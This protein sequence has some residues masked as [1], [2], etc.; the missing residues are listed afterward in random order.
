MGTSLMCDVCWDKKKVI[1]GNCWVAYFDILGFSKRV[2]EL[3]EHLDVFV[4]VYYE[5]ILAEI[6]GRSRRISQALRNEIRYAWFSDTFIFFSKDAG[7]QS[8]ISIELLSREFLNSQIYARHPLRGALSV[9]EFYSEKEKDIFVGPALIDAY[10]YA[11]RQN[12]IG[13]VLTPKACGN[14]NQ[15]GIQDR[16][17]YIEYDV[18]FKAGKS[19]RLLAYKLKMVVSGENILLEH[20]H[21]MQQEAKNKYPDEYEARYK[22]IYENTL[23]FMESTKVH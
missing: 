18:P 11:E 17:N 15:H 20:I 7:P 12:W 16:V 21:Q 2:N 13:F 5:D 9:G 1:N 6:K 4:K 19:K 22:T 8:Y 14:L 3:K 10:K 23:K